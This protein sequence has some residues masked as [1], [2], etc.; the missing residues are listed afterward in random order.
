MVRLNQVLNKKMQNPAFRTAFEA[1][2]QE[3]QLSQG[4]VDLTQVQDEK[5]A[6]TYVRKATN[7]PNHGLHGRLVHA[8]P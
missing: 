1:C 8:E 6:K 7:E 3:F 2:E 5:S 4:L